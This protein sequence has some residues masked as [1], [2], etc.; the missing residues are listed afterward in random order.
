M[1]K[2]LGEDEPKAPAPTVVVPGATAAETA[3]AVEEGAIETALEGGDAQAEETPTVI[4]DPTEQPME[5]KP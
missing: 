2:L 1:E 3:Q 4:V 5:K